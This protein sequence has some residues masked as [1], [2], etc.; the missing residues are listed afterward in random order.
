[1]YLQKSVVT[2]IK[3][4]MNKE[5]HGNKCDQRECNLRDNLQSMDEKINI[6]L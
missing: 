2:G 5:T 6:F 4:C 3:N 1:M